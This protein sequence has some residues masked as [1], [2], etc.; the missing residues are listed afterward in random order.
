MTTY[1]YARCSTADQHL[2]GQIEQLTAVGCTKIYQEKVSGSKAGATR[3][4]LAAMLSA[5]QPGDVVVVCKID[6]IARSTRDLLN[7][8]G[9][10]ESA[11]V[12]F[13]AL[14]SP[15]DTSTSEGKMMMQ[16]LGVIAE[17]ERNLLLD[18]Q[19]DGIRR[20]KAEGK[21]TGREPTARRQT[22][23]VLLMLDMGVTRVA[24]ARALGVSES[25]VYRIQRQRSGGAK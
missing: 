10:M 14:N 17:F 6:R 8:L 23:E 5:A 15:L 22:D 19:K 3:P 11:G 25:S 2:D 16:M 24:V 9:D 18:R 1:G 12:V 4:Q 21:Y 13:K 7:M 20:A